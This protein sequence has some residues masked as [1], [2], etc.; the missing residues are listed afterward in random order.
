MFLLIP[1]DVDSDLFHR[2][3]IRHRVG[4]VR[5]V[6]CVPQVDRDAPGAEFI[7]AFGASERATRRVA[8]LARY[9]VSRRTALLVGHAV[10][11]MKQVTISDPWYYPVRRRGLTG[12]ARLPI[13]GRTAERS[14][15]RTIILTSESSSYAP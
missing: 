13:F 11:H 12:R 1:R 7:P 2:R 9:P 6:V 3:E 14:F 15:C 5:A 8:P 4:A 10:R